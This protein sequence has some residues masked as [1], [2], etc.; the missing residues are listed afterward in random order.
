MPEKKIY[1][2]CIC[3]ESVSYDV[4]LDVLQK[5]MELSKSGLIQISVPHKDH[6][7]A[8]YL[9]R[10]FVVRGVSEILDIN[11]IATGIK[12]KQDEINTEDLRELLEKFDYNKMLDQLISAVAFKYGEK[13]TAF[14]VLGS[15]IGSEIWYNMRKRYIEMGAKLKF[16]PNTILKDE[17]VPV[18]KKISS[19]VNYFKKSGLITVLLKY[20]AKFYEGV[21]KG[22][23]EKMNS[24]GIIEEKIEVSFMENKDRNE[25]WVL[26]SD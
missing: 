19:G 7:V 18:L 4:D 17:I 2:V 22:A 13:D 3:G 8:L 24:V 21:I 12:E 20:P 16:Q 15:L 25:L 1:F 26:P 14:E 6:K 9:D 10:N 23:L 11:E 5:K